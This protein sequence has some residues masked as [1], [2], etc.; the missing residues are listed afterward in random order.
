M[1]GANL[2]HFVN[3]SLDL[4]LRVL[5]QPEE[6]GNPWEKFPK[7]QSPYFSVWDISAIAG[8]LSY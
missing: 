5:E 1:W 2:V 7:L 3:T 4:W 8:F 6:R